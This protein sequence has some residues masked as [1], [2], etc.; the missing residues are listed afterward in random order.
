MR[1]TIRW[2][3]LRPEPINSLGS[4]RL[5]PNLA[6]ASNP[7]CT[8]QT[9]ANG[10]FISRNGNFVA[11]AGTFVNGPD[12]DKGPSSL[13]LDHIFQVNG[14]VNLPWKFQVSGIFRAQSGFHFSR[15]DE[16]S[17]DPDGNGN[18]NSIDFT[19]G[20]NAFTAPPYVD[21]DMRFAKSFVFRE[22]VKI[23]V[24]LEFFNLLNRQNPA[25][26]QNRTIDHQPSFW[27]GDPGSAGTGRPGGFQD[28]ILIDLH[29]GINQ[30]KCTGPVERPGSSPILTNFIE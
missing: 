15:F 5:L 17:R 23:Q 14:A 7:G 20:R 13:A 2:V 3:Y 27:T 6:A 1:P 26:I 22:R 25:Q 18:F 28:R 21:L 10:S 29:V 16:L 9:N 11:Q 30:C 24:L 8:K 12:L 4:P 19:A